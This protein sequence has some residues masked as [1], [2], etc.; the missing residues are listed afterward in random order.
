MW[1]QWNQQCRPCSYFYT[2]TTHFFPSQNLWSVRLQ[3]FNLACDKYNIYNIFHSTVL[4]RYAPTLNCFCFLIIM[5]VRDIK[6]P[7]ALLFT[8]KKMERSWY[9]LKSFWLPVGIL[10]KLAC[11]QSTVFHQILHKTLRCCTSF[12]LDSK[13]LWIVLSSPDQIFSVL[14]AWK[15]ACM[16]LKSCLRFICMK[17]KWLQEALPCLWESN[18]LSIASILFKPASCSTPWSKQRI[19]KASIKKLVSQKGL[20]LALLRATQA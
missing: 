16:K 11:D 9:F 19:H 10:S 15:L 6:D 5:A 12:F 3:V 8:F 2:Q 7:C 17:Q 13:K 20:A 14:P 18:T 4:D 1:L